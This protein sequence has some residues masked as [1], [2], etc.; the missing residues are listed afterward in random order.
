MKKT[1]LSPSFWFGLL[2]SLIVCLGISRHFFQSAIFRT[3]DLE[4][5]A[6]RLAHF[7]LAI[8][9]GEFPPVWEINT[10]EGFGMPTY[11][12]TYFFPYLFAVCWYF[13]THSIELSLNL[14]LFAAL[15]IMTLGAYLL[16]WRLS[17]N[18][19]VTVFA[20]LMYLTL[21]YQ[22]VNIFIRGALGEV[23]FMSLVP[24]LML[25][26]SLDKYKNKILLQVSW[27]IIWCLLITTH[28]L[29]I[30]F[31]VPI[32]VAW[33]LTRRLEEIKQKKW[34]EVFPVTLVFP[35]VIAI[36][37]TSIFTLPMVFE[38]QHTKIPGNESLALYY[39]EFSKFNDLFYSEW[40]NGGL[41][42]EKNPLPPT[43]MIGAPAWIT[44]SF[45]LI[46]LFKP[47]ST[48]NQPK[49]QARLSTE[50]WLW[51]LIMITAIWMMTPWSDVLWRQSS[52]LQMQQF[53]WRLNWIVILTAFMLY[54]QL[55]SR[56]KKSNF[57][58][59]VR[60][61]ILA[62]AS[63]AILIWGK[64]ID[65]VSTDDFYWFQYPLTGMYFQE[66]L[67][68][69]FS[70]HLNFRLSDQVV[71]REEGKNVFDTPYQ[72]TPNLSGS[73]EIT[74]WSGHHMLYQV[75]T[76][77]SA[78]VIQKTANFPG[79]EARVNNE[80]VPITDDDSEFPGRVVFA[81][82]KGDSKIEVQFTSQ[83]TAK[84]IGKV[85]SGLGITAT[86]IWFGWQFFHRKQSS[87]AT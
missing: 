62:N 54:I 52:L 32:V 36:L 13:L 57:R 23:I 67:P 47:V 59:L 25:L 51:C 48:L 10:N 50:S 37:L 61:V 20:T 12:F 44:L 42:G 18:P 16:A 72:P 69:N 6:A 73:Y 11:N 75:H 71:I 77:N 84:V 26:I 80:V 24:W 30:I 21:P 28:H 27:I 56:L 60:L 38:S 46:L 68:K 22:M 19:F 35:T 65:T 17:K 63:M 5:H 55:E 14:T 49:L 1:S 4:I 83:T 79:W 86:F 76:E 58:H 45:V 33:Y 3:H 39:Q 82:P 53:P 29:L 85:L 74:T 9:N 78:Q 34:S 41:D 2:L 40:S 7:Y 64:P 81:V 66:L 87:E 15:L 43:R 8:K 31:L 70:T